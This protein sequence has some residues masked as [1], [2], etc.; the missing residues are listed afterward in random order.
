MI[1]DLIEYLARLLDYL[2]KRLCHATTP[3][4][5]CFI[6]IE[7]DETTSMR[8]PHHALPSQTKISDSEAQSSYRDMARDG[9]TGGGH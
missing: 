2:I 9:E 4:M 3:L 7:T 5:N 8:S 1:S 6:L